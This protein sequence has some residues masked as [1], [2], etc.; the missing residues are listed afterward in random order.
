[1]KMLLLRLEGALQSWGEWA[2]WDERDTSLMP[3][4]SGVLGL[5]A[6]CMGCKRGDLLIEELHRK[7]IYAVRSDRPGSLMTDYHTVHSD[8]L[9]TAEGKKQNRTIVS[10]R[11]YLM[12]SAFLVALG[13][14]D[15]N[16]EPLLDRCERALR[17]PKW[18]PYLGRKSCV[19][20]APVLYGMETR[21][22]S[23]LEALQALDLIDQPGKRKD[24]RPLIWYET[25]EAG[26]RH[27]DCLVDAE[28]RV[29]TFNSYHA[30]PYFGTEKEA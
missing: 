10:H 24:S 2:K 11:Q 8:T 27:P 20:S 26:S 17:H 19:P 30:V 13:V 7:L 6:C 16:D 3:T 4:K 14:I 25:M 15:S 12:D 29:F 23:P 9:R 18:T 21:F 28:R 5:I 22:G 1:M